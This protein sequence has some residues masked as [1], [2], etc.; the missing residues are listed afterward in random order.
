MS[1]VQPYTF[2]HIRNDP[3]RWGRWV[4][5]AIG[6]HLINQ[7]LEDRFRVFY[8]RHRNDEIDFVIEGKGKVIGLEVKTAASKPTSGMDAFRKQ[9]EPDHILMVGSSGISVEKF[10]ETRVVDLLQ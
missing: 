1:A 5:S 10:L 8:W 2:H 6:A 9:F 4:E 7:S 3:K